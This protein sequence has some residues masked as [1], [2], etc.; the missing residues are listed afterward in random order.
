MS[1]RRHR[2]WALALV[3]TALLAVQLTEARAQE[4]A[5]PPQSLN[6]VVIHLP[7]NPAL[8]AST[9]LVVVDM[10]RI[11]EVAQAIRVMRDG[12]TSARQ[13]FQAEMRGREAELQERD[14]IL[15]AARAS[16]DPAD[17]QSQRD[18][19]AR[20]L[21]LLQDDIKVW[22]RDHDRVMNQALRRTQEVLLRI[23]GDLASERGA[24]VVLPKSSI[25]LIQPELDITESALQRLNEELP[26]LPMPDL[27]QQ[28]GM[29]RE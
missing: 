7:P 5:S 19:L 26:S 1:C 15:A 23:V 22:F 24:I 29:P 8:T 13:S 2:S 17:F 16:M 9:P 10:Q 6:G 3:F 18:Q 27:L 20:D 11:L 4:E 14:S 25:V 21:A 12:M 28:P